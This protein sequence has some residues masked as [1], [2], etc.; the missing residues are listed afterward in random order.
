[1]TNKTLE[2]SVTGGLGNQLYQVYTCLSLSTLLNRLPILNV[3]SFKQYKDHALEVTKLFPNMRLSHRRPNRLALNEFK[4]KG[5]GEDIDLYSYLG[6][7]SCSSNIYL[8]GYFQS[9]A[10]LKNLSLPLLDYIDQDILEGYTCELPVDQLR[11]SIGIH[12]RRGNKQSQRNKKIYGDI[13][14]ELHRD[15]ILRVSNKTK[16]VIIFTDDQDYGHKLITSL[17]LPCRTTL[18]SDFNAEN[19]SVKELIAFSLCKELVIS[20]STFSLWAAYFSKHSRIY[21]PEPFYPQPEH[22]TVYSQLFEDR[23]KPTW[24]SYPIKYNS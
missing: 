13:S 24:Y 22:R 8:S 5:L 4:E 6:S 11:R 20:N 19:D 15:M 3:S 21:Y 1:M 9:L 7:H 23:C 10:Y 14:C 17:R 18:S 2:V 12:I 16:H